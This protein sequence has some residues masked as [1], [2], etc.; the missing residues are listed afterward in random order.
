MPARWPASE[1]RTSATIERMG[2]GGCFEAIV[3]AGDV[4]AGKPD[5]AVYRL[6]C[7]RLNVAPQT[8]LAFDD[9]C[10]GVRAAILAGLRCIGL[11]TN[12][13]RTQLLE[14]GAELVI[15]DSTGFGLDSFLT[16]SEELK[17]PAG[18]YRLASETSQLC[19][20][21]KPNGRRAG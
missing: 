18:Q 20:Y 14:E 11:A 6:A 9:S 17:G 5:P 12:G 15:A 8:A 7:E 2:L 3:T 21:G 1:I 13:F 19:G 4:A 16:R 10:A